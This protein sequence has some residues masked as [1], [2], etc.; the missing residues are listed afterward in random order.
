[1]TQVA[2]VKKV[3]ADGTAEVSVHVYRPA[4]TTAASVPAAN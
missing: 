2:L 3:L 4:A 1:M